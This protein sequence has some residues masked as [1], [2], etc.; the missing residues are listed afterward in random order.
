MKEFELRTPVRNKEGYVVGKKVVVV[1]E[2]IP[3]LAI[4]TP[5]QFTDLISKVKENNNG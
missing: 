2:Y 1:P 5:K 4:L 3:N